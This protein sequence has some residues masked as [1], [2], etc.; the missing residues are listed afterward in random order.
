MTDHGLIALAAARALAAFYRAESAACR[1]A[2]ALAWASGCELRAETLE[3]V[4]AEAALWRRAAG[5]RD[6]DAADAAP[7]IHGGD[8]L[9]AP[10]PP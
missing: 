10:A 9:R 8:D 1:A 4:A 3:R 5:W 6:P 2:G 7:L